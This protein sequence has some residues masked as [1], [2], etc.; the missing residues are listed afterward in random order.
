MELITCTTC[1]LTKETVYFYKSKRHKLGYTPMCK[2]CE[3]ARK[4][5]SYDPLKRKNDYVKN[6]DQNLLR[7]RKYN[8]ANKEA[9]QKKRKEYYNN[10]KLLF[11]EN[12]W[13]KRGILNKNSEFFKKKD[14]DELFEKAGKCC[15]ICKITTPNHTKGFFVDHCHTTGFARGIICGHCNTGLGGFKDDITNLKNAIT[16]LDK[17]VKM[18]VK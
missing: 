2:S 3:S 13:K 16:Y 11:L 1:K 7:S 9:I 4:I 6:K 5:K 18:A 10:N 15:E 8:D 14:F 12:S 17:I